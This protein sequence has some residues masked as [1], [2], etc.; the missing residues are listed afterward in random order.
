[1]LSLCHL[2]FHRAL[3]QTRLLLL[4]LY[5]RRTRK[6]LLKLSRCPLSLSYLASSSSLLFLLKR[7]LL[8]PFN[9]LF[10]QLNSLLLLQFL[11][12]LFLHL[13]IQLLR[14]LLLLLDLLYLLLLGNRRLCDL[15]QL[16]LTCASHLLR[17]WLLLLLLQ[18]GLIRRRL[19]MSQL[20][21]DL[22]L[23]L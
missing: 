6:V 15:D 23:I 13:P 19:L 10:F 11:P 1:L 9:P 16:L 2:L 17:G 14:I 12:L 5:Y 7:P 4:R 20:L 18:R 8:L 3:L 22:D 21:L